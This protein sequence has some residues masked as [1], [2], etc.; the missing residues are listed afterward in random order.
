MLFNCFQRS[1]FFV[2]LPWRVRLYLFGWAY[3]LANPAAPA[4][5]P[6]APYAIDTWT[7]ADGLPQNSVTAIAQTSD[8]YFWLGTFNGLVRFDGTRFALFDRDNVSAFVDTQIRSLYADKKGRL[9]IF[10]L[11]FPAR[12]VIRMEA[13]RF[14]LENI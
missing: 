8:G 6:I 7:T 10:D 1:R 12:S 2:R 13:G 11:S 5:L 14:T 3:C 9:W 4:E